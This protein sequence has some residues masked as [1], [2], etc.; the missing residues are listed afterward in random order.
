MH[1]QMM[2]SMM[3]NTFGAPFG[4]DPFMSSKPMIGNIDT[5]IE[6][7]H[8]RMGESQSLDL[9]T[10]G[11]GSRFVQKQSMTKTKAGADGKPPISET[12]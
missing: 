11:Q 10:M 8:K 12:Y 3:S 9:E 7:A 4:R 1:Q 5:M 2:D 6:D